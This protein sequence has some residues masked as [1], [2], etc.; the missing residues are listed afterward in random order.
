VGGAGA[1]VSGEPGNPANARALIALAPGPVGAGAIGGATVGAPRPT[2]RPIDGANPGGANGSPTGVAPRA[3]EVASLSAPTLP[4]GT[5][6]PARVGGAGASPGP[7]VPTTA[8]EPNLGGARLAGAREDRPVGPGNLASSFGE[9]SSAPAIGPA[10]AAGGGLGGAGLGPKPRGGDVVAVP[11]NLEV[12]IAGPR[13][14]A[15]EPLAQRSV[16]ARKPLLEK[17]GGT[18]QSEDAVDRALAYLAREQEPDGHWTYILPSS[19]R[20]RRGRYPH[21]MALT[22]LATLSFL[23][24]DHTPNRTGPYR[25]AVENAVNYLIEG[26]RPNGDLRGRFPGGGADAGNMYDHGI[27]TLALCEAA[28]MTGDARITA[29]ATK[30]A[31]FVVKAQNRES[32]GWRYVPGEYGDTSVFGWQVMALHSAQ[33]LGFEWP[34]ASRDAALKYV[35]IASAGRQKSLGG[36]QPGNSATPPMSAELLF[37]RI[38]LGQKLTE[39][40]EEEAC[41]YLPRQ[42]TS[43]FYGTYYASL[44]LVQLQNDTWKQ[45]NERTRENLI[46]LQRKGG[47]D[48]G[49]WDM[50]VQWGERAGRVYSTALACLTLEVYYRYLPLNDDGSASQPA[51]GPALPDIGYLNRQ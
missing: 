47:D 12:A 31:E 33:Q 29:A 32:G 4:G 19:E 18:K 45:W 2:T 21:D 50:N 41:A 25:E 42:S 39:E 15:P 36:Y 49:C 10:A 44:S 48:D 23:A 34:Q 51:S 6:G 30:G 38:L 26:Q 5:R 9:P 43:D 13:V 7:S 37:A 20:G 14:A 28:L 46:R 27:A 11:L 35:R 1:T 3:P 40:Q 17:M 16:A 22:G 8:D 24:A